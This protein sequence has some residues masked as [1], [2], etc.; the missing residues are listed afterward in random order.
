[1]WTAV[2]PE[3]L[4]YEAPW[5]ASVKDR[6]AALSARTRRVAYFY[7][8]P[9]TASFRYRAFNMVEALNA[10]P[11]LEISATWFTLDDASFFARFLERADALVVCRSRYDAQVADLIMRAKA[12]GI[13]VAFDT[14]DLLFDINSV[15]LIL[16][17]IGVDTDSQANWNNW[18]AYIARLSAT[19]RLCDRVIVTNDYLA[20]RV[21]RSFPNIPTAILPN[22]LNRT[23]QQVS[24][25]IW[26]RKQASAFARN[27]QLHIGYF[28]G[29][30]THVRDFEIAV[31]A[32][33]QIMARH[34]E[35]V[36]RI[37]GHLSI[38]DA[39]LPFSHRIERFPMQDF[40]NLQRLTGEV[41]L[42]IAPVQ[43]NSFT[44]CKSELKY[45]E[46]AIVGAL[47]VASPIQPFCHAIQDGENG[48]L[49]RA[50]EWESKLEQALNVIGDP[51]R[52]AAML[53]RAHRHT[54][55]SYAWDR[56]AR[57]IAAAIFGER[58]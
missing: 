28:S 48:F 13:L 52:C 23:Q 10:S 1:M 21:A 19:L 43:D 37:V 20:G 46:A 5:S 4:P 9:D 34:P 35:L 6:L 32:L 47:T 42:S 38:P 30:A 24:D 58:S 22:F 31:P 39:L 17:T 15:H 26:K 40:L 55:E 50:Q 16:N 2:S 44:N 41:E 29:T 36:L 25:D 49:A 54:E 7:E 53:E 3:P 27:G 14:D 33:T 12:G 56:Q 45:F 18:F 8:Q 57:R 11:D 51:Q